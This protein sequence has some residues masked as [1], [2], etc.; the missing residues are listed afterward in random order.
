MTAQITGAYLRPAFFA[1]LHFLSGDV[2]VWSGTGTINWNGNDWL[3][4][5]TLG[6]ISTIE[7]SSDIKANNLTL[8]LSGIPSDALAQAMGETR[9]GNPVT[10]WFGCLGDNN[11]VLADPIKSFAGRM[12]VPLI[13]EGSQTSTISITVESILVDLQRS[14]LRNYTHEDQQIDF[15]GDLGF[16]YVPGLQDWNGVWGKPSPGHGSPVHLGGPFGPGRGVGG[17]GPFR[18]N[19]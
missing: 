3:G 7:E 17:G 11:N 18:P 9:Q 10:I 2:F 15:P 12:D 8:T 19:R 6:Q 1:Q 5:G 14:R 4:L 13:E 16:E